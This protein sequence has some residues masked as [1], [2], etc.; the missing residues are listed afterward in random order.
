MAAVRG[1]EETSATLQVDEYLR[2]RLCPRPGDP[3]YLHLADLRRALAEFE[4]ADPIDLLDYGCG[5]SPYRRLFPNA[6]YHRADFVTVEGLDFLTDADGRLPDVGIEQYDLVL[7]TQVLEHVATPQ[8]Y[9][10]E[11]LRVLKPGG[12]I[13]L[14]T[15]GVFPDH[16]CP[17]DFW[18]WTTDGLKLELTRA[19]FEVEKQYRLTAGPRAVMCWMGQLASTYDTPSQTLPRLGARVLR[20][21]YRWNRARI[22]RFVDRSFDA[23]AVRCGHSEEAI[24]FSIGLLAS[25]RKPVRTTV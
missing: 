6:T 12:R 18:R 19:G 3:L 22:D 17:Y 5:G 23:Y 13:L 2:Q 16:G 7:S 1:L 11:A 14:T 8:A 4:T 25:A 24:D 15:H 20:K 9:L 21:L 10:Q